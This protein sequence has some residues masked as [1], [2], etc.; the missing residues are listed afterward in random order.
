MHLI[1][2]HHIFVIPA[3]PESFF[4]LRRISDA[5]LAGMT[6]LDLAAQSD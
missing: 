5:P 1:L 3:C 2:L 6:T 4:V